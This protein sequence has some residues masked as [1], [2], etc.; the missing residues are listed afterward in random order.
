LPS[1]GL[2]MPRGAGRGWKGGEKK[3]DRREKGREVMRLLEAVLDG[4]PT[5]FVIGPR[6]LLKFPQGQERRIAR[7]ASMH[8]GVFGWQ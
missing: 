3:S 2:E 1:A 7:R 5:R 6:M 8:L 4:D